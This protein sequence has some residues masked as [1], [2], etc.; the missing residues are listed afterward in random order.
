METAFKFVFYFAIFIFIL[1]IISLFLLL[2]KVF[3]IFF[4]ELRFMGL[5]IRYS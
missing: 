4:P 2:L 1:I 5:L 3:L